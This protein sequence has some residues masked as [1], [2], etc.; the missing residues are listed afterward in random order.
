MT[1]TYHD[2]IKATLETISMRHPDLSVEV[3]FANDVEGG[4]AYA[5]FPD[6]G[7]APS[8]VLSSDIPVF[9][10]PGVIAHEVAHVVVGIDAMHG[11]V[12]EAEYRAIMLDLHRAIVGEEAGPDVIAEIDE[13]VAMSRASDEDGTATDYVKAAE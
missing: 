1:I 10:V 2:P 4:A 9:A 6:D 5:M 3:H 12:W 8:I 7:A 11:P 13:E